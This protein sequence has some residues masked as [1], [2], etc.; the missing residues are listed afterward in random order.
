M[1]LQLAILD[2]A[3]DAVFDHYDDG[4]FASFDAATVEI[5]GGGRDGE[6]LTVVIEPDSA[7][8]ERWNRPG[9][10]LQVAIPPER[11]DLQ[12]LF[13]GAFTIEGEA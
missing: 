3:K 4:S 2:Y 9:R 6:K 13:S 1:R 12:T 8:A 5:V 11:L 10:T 7:D